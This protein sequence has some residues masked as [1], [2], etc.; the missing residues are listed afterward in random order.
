[1]ESA[2]QHPP[3]RPGPA[4]RAA[5]SVKGRK[6]KSPRPTKK[7]AG[8]PYRPTRLCPHRWCR[9]LH[10]VLLLVA[11][12]IALRAVFTDWRLWALLALSAPLTMLVMRLIYRA[13]PLQLAIEEAA[14]AGTGGPRLLARPVWARAALV[15]DLCVLALAAHRVGQDASGQQPYQM[16][17]GTAEVIRRLVMATL[18]GGL[19]LW[20]H[21]KATQPA[22]PK[23]VLVP[24]PAA[25]GG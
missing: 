4:G 15:C 23:G 6:V 8:Q 2:Q 9:P 24:A 11:T 14:H 3:S 1:M 20:T 16:P 25:H 18:I 10:T 17:D 22:Q 21:W 13:T 5:R 7:P 19:L 12:S